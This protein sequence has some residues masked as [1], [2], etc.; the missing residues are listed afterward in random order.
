LKLGKNYEKDI[1]TK[2]MDLLGFSGSFGKGDVI[3]KLK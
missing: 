2:K 1:I 3:K